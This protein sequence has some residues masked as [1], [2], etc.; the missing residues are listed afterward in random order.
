MCV[1]DAAID[2]LFGL[3]YIFGVELMRGVGDGGGGSS[4]DERTHTH[5][6]HNNINSLVIYL[7]IRYVLVINVTG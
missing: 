2:V 3:G 7:V 5:T 4:T 1:G 6:A